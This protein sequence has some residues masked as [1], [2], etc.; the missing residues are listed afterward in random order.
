MYYLSV[1]YSRRRKSSSRYTYILREARSFTDFCWIVLGDLT[2]GKYRGSTLPFEFP[3]YWHNFR[4][5]TVYLNEGEETWR[6]CHYPPCSS[7]PNSLKAFTLHVDCFRLVK[8][9][10]LKLSL[11]SILLSGLWTSP[12]AGLYHLR[13]PV[14]DIAY[15]AACAD[16]VTDLSGIIM[17]LKTLPVELC[18]MIIRECPGSP[19]W[20]Y[21]VVNAFG[22]H[23]GLLRELRMFQ[24]RDAE[25]LYGHTS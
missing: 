3:P 8:G 21:S 11:P 14:R 10:L 18:E 20:R 15:L 6:L 13:R 2:N 4:N 7:C 19:L 12:S 23:Y 5:T 24:K 1:L 22:I 9:R 17:G 25:K 16:P